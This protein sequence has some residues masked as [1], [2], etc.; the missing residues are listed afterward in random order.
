MGEHGLWVT[1]EAVRVSDSFMFV[2][3]TTGSNGGRFLQVGYRWQEGGAHQD[4]WIFFKTDE[5]RGVLKAPWLDAW[6][7][8]KERMEC[9][10]R[11]VWEGVADGRG[12]Y[13]APPGPDR[14]WRISIEGAGEKGLIMRMFNISPEGNEGLAVEAVYERI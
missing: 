12:R 10:G 8:G 9:E 4:G 2:K 11:I 7:L 3:P 5:G 14:G 13:A 6:H 1:G